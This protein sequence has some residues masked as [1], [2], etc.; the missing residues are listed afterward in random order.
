MHIKPLK[1]HQALTPFSHEH[2]HSLLLS[3]KIRRGISS[4]IPLKRIK[5]YTDWFF[6][7]HIKQHFEREEEYI[8]PILGDDNALVKR[9]LAEHRRLE[10]L[11]AEK[12][13][14][15]RSLSLLEEEL[16]L[17]IRFEER[18]L[19]KEVQKVATPEMLENIEAIH[20]ENDFEDNLN[21]PFWKSNDA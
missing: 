15:E 3:W 19:F 7:N 1:R 21:D 14:L 17:H 8:F 18:V 11:F 9:A 20:S 4:N 5:K 12:V 13:D 2:H 10:R 6:K 16:E